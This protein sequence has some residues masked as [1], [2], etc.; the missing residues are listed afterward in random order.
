M[1]DTV[2]ILTT[3]EFLTCSVCGIRFAAPGFWLSKRRDDHEIFYCPSGHSQYFPA[4]SQAEIAISDRN[5]VQAKLN[6]A[7]HAQVVLEKKLNEEKAKL[8]R[9]E[10]RI[11]HGICPC[12]NRSFKDLERHM[13]LKHKGGIGAGRPQKQ[14][15]AG[16]P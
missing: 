16:A 7:L 9:L 2:S 12:C 1:G 5:K 8:A 11:S 14:I 15:E 6:E 4:K 3:M 10:T 13:K